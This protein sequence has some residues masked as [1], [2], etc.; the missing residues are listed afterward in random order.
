MNAT[1][2]R[3]V[4]KRGCHLTPPRVVNADEKDLGNF[5]HDQPSCLSR[6][7]QPLST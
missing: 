1:L 3:S 7:G 4:E 6:R 5:L 2:R